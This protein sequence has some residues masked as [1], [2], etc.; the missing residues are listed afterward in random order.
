MSKVGFIGTGHIAAPV[1]RFLHRKGHEV[2]VTTRSAHV[3]SALARDYGIAVADGPGVLDTSD[4]ICLCVRPQ[5][6]EEVLAGLPWRADHRIISVM[7]GVSRRDLER[8]CAPASTFVQTIPLGFLEQGGC[9]LAAFGDDGL[10]AELFAPDNPVVPVASEDALNA[11]F[12]I[13]AM[14]PGLLD[15]MATGADW[16]AGESGDTAN[17]EFYT[18][19]LVAG[20]LATLPRETGALAKERDALATAGTLSLQM[21]DGLKAGGAHDALAQT[22]DAIGERLRP[23]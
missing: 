8:L 18:A 9:P 15:L 22:L 11:H 10:L 21:T 7:A 17:A 2:T 16:L 14:V 3:S 12:A 5:H 4:I 1:A 13:C 23:A 6:A 19:Q 20:F